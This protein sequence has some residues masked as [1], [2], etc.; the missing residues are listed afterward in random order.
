VLVGRAFLGLGA[1]GVGFDCLV[2]LSRVG[3]PSREQRYETL[4]Y[5]WKAGRLAQRV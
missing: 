4:Y 2:E 5:L 1:E 3:R